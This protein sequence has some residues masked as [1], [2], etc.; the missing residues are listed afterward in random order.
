MTDKCD[1]VLDL[2]GMNCPYSLLELNAVFKD[3]RPGAAVE[4][5]GD[6]ASLVDEIQRWCEATGNRMESAETEASGSAP[7]VRLIVRKM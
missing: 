2:S 6:R 3:M 5:A 4:V 1:H 7:A